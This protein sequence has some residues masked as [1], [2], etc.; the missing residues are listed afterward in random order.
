MKRKYKAAKNGEE[1]T[2]VL[3]GASEKVLRD[4]NLVISRATSTLEQ[5]AEQYANLSLS[6]SFSAQVGSAVRLLEQHYASL[7][8]KGVD[9]EQLQKVKQSLDH[10][11]RKLGLLNVARK[12]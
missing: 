6:G 1:K 2:A 12:T 9:P 3:V 4:L 10:M 5:L 7:E 8:K 11:K